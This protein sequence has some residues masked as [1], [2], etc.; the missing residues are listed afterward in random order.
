MFRIG[1]FSL[2]TDSSW[3]RATRLRLRSGILASCIAHAAMFGATAI[4]AP[5]MRGVDASHSA[6]APLAVRLALPAPSPAVASP[7]AP[8]EHAARNR[9]RTATRAP[10]PLLIG[11]SAPV[12]AAAIGANAEPS[13]LETAAAMTSDS[14]AASAS[15]VT[16][17][18]QTRSAG[19][20]VPAAQGGHG[21][22]VM[23]ATSLAEPAAHAPRF[24]A[25]Y[26]HN[27]APAYPALSRRVGEQ[28]RVLL[29]VLVDVNG[30]PASIELSASSGS[31]RLDQSAL[32][33]VKRW[34]FV[35]ARKGELPVSAWVVVP[36]LFSLNG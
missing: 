21:T 34:K 1:H 13:P 28:G 12:T 15:P 19:L 5:G 2:A 14:S 32:E 10:N 25:A 3:A 26:L 20:A 8:R 36:I 24:D 4:L 18:T 23:Q 33:A 29:R 22:P 35:P 7:P 27:E 30:V 9:P 16:P 31:A 17:A 11:R 6:I